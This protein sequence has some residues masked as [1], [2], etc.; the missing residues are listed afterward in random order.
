MGRGSLQKVV[1]G[2]TMHHFDFSL[3]YLIGAVWC[4]GYSCQFMFTTIRDAMEAVLA[5]AFS[6]FFAAGAAFLFTAALS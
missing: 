1:S 5:M 2:D 3:F 4:L 6:L